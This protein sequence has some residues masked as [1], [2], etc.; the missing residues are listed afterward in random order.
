M[1]AVSKGL[2]QS[3]PITAKEAAK[4][5]GNFST[6]END[7][8]YK[9]LIEAYTFWIEN[10]EPY[11][12]KGGTVPDSPREELL[13]ILLDMKKPSDNDLMGFLSDPRRDVRD[14]AEKYLVTRIDEDTSLRE[15][16]ISAT[17]EEIIDPIYLSK[18]IKNNTA[19]SPLQVDSICEMINH[20]NSKVKYAAFNILHTNHV[21]NEMLRK[22]LKVAMKDGNDEIRE[23][24][25]L[26]ESRL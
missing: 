8:L 6:P 9:T 11:P 2:F 1:D 5:A 26:L 13:T 10:E 23:S 16:L 18:T 25:V 21:S 20:E 19:F 7:H 17:S 3:G 12:T 15:K 4:L 24:A 22:W 14:V